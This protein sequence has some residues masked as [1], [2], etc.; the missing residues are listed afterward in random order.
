MIHL[1][2]P[3]LG[4]ALTLAGTTFSNGANFYAFHGHADLQE[5]IHQRLASWFSVE[6]MVKVYQVYRECHA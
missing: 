6:T 2:L 5:N 3:T 1:P 4:L